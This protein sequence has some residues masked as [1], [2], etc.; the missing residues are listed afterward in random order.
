MHHVVKP[1]LDYDLW[2]KDLFMKESW[3]GDGAYSA[4]FS[5]SAGKMMMTKD[6]HHL[7][8]QHKKREEEDGT[9]RN[10]TMTNLGEAAGVKPSK[11]SHHHQHHSGDPNQNFTLECYQSTPNT[12]MSSSMHAQDAESKHI[13][14]SRPWQV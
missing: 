9:R 5:T 7:N 11:R 1:R 14:R 6:M 13:W 3:R 10:E 12:L 4:I 2:Q 8:Q